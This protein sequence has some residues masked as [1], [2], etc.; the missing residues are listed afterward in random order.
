MYAPGL[1]NASDLQD[2][3]A[4]LKGLTATGETALMNNPQNCCHEKKVCTFLNNPETWAMRM[5]APHVLSKM[6]RFARQAWHET[7]WSG[8]ADTP[9]PLYSMSSTSTTSSTG[10]SHTTSGSLHLLPPPLSIRVAEHWEY[11]VG[12]GLVDPH[13]YDVDS[14][15]TIVALLSDESTLRFAFGPTILSSSIPWRRATLFVSCHT[16]I[17]MSSQLPKA[18]GAAL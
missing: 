13:H 3:T 1:L 9:G 15:L 6:I 4:V 8:D 7:D 12:G 18:Y 5:H 16:N 17:T 14:V 10:T 2:I 11:S